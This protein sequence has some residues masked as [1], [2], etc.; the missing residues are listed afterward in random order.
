MRIKS[1]KEKKTNA[2]YMKRY[3]QKHKGEIG[4]RARPPMARMAVKAF[5]SFFREFVREFEKS[6]EEAFLMALELTT[7]ARLEQAMKYHPESIKKWLA[8]DFAKPT[9]EREARLSVLKNIRMPRKYRAAI[10][11]RGSNEG[12]IRMQRPTKE[13]T[14][15]APQ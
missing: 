13:Q 1:E 15:E 11:T 8:G 12:S 6:N 9:K 5:K 14:W 4:D 2:E 3:R 7:H 10:G